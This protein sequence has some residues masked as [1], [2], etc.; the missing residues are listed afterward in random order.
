MQSHYETS[1]DNY[2][3]IKTGDGSYTLYNKKYGAYY[4]SLYGAKSESEYV[5]IQQSNLLELLKKRRSINILEIGLGTG[6]NLLV[7]ISKVM[8]FPGVKVLYY[9]YEPE[10]LHVKIWEKFLRTYD[11]P[12]VWWVPLL[13]KETHFIVENVEVNIFWEKWSGGDPKDIRFDIIYYDAFGPR[14]HPE[15]WEEKMLISAYNSLIKGGRLVTFSI[16]GQ[17][18]RILKK[19][20]I[21][22][23]RPK[24]FG[25]KREMLVIK[26]G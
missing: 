5:F 26:K 10:P 24:G 11:F 13:N 4:H 6:L 7:T 15:M 8:E 19:H 25:K 17:T 9:A 20:N 12:E 1:E 3:L 22:F 18:K 23:E 2:E 14:Q 21:L 16:T